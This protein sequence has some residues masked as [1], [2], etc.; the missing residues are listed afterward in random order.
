MRYTAQCASRF[1][2]AKDPIGLASYRA[3]ATIEDVRVDHRRADVRPDIVSILEQ[4]GRK[5]VAQ[6]VRRRTLLRRRLGRAGFVDG[7]RGCR[8]RAFRDGVIRGWPECCER[9]R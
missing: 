2:Y 6:G 8:P 4:A 5:R 1:S 3:R 9:E 7:V